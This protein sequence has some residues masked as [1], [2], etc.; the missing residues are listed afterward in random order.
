MRRCLA[1][2][3]PVALLGVALG[4]TVACSTQKPAPRKAPVP[5]PDWPRVATVGGAA[6]DRQDDE[7]EWVALLDRLVAQNVSVVEADSALSEYLNDD[8]FEAELT[9]VRRFSE[10][11]H[12][13]NLKVV[14]YYPSLEVITPNGETAEHSMFKDHPDWV[15][16]GL[17]EQDP[18]RFAPNVFYGSKVFWVAPGAESAWMCHLSP[19]REYLLGRIRKVAATGVDGIWLD[20][21]LFNDIVGKWACYHDL[22]R[23]KFHA[24]TGYEIPRLQAPGAELDSNDPAWRVWV[25]WRHREIDTFLRDVLAA[26]RSVRPDIAL[27]VET[28]TMDYNAA[29]LEGLDGSFAGP[30]ADYWHVWEVDVLSDS[31]AMT[32]ANEDDWASLA[33]MFKFGRGADR[34]R[35][36]WTFTY[37][38]EPDDAEAVLAEALAA[39]VCPYELKVPEMTTTVGADYRRRVFGWI[40]AHEDIL[41][42]S[43]SA[44]RV[45]VVHSSA[46][47]DYRDGACVLGQGPLPDEHCGVS[48][49]ATWQ[50]PDPDLA[51]WTSDLDDSL[52]QSIYLAEYRGFVKALMRLHVP[53]DV[54]PAARLPVEAL[55]AYDLLILPDPLALSDAEAAALRGFVE[56][57]GRLLVTGPSPGALDERGLVRGSPAL[58]GLIADA[59]EGGCADVTASSGVVRYCRA[60]PGRAVLRTTDAEALATIQQAVEALSTAVVQTDA[61]PRVHLELYRLGPK[62]ILH[63]VNATGVDGSFSVVPQTFHVGV[64]AGAA[65]ITRV[66]ATSARE[67]SDREVPFVRAGDFV[68]FDA[69]VAIH[70]VFVLE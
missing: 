4:W 67:D 58:S 56:A 60:S 23:A 3:R 69:T 13:R 11:A 30:D 28:V 6:L 48:L 43:E 50:R 21:P 39:Q 9:M 19:Y 25:H 55:S 61:G 35:A 18:S 62:T 40:R 12:E 2:L 54:I 57:G 1:R 27:V 26:A 29:L 42:R 34:G 15:Q 65:P 37:G 41:F 63:A 32:H 10:L 47:R 70:S 24:D 66:L 46:S 44:A 20:V 53:H 51:W 64:R 36:A 33:A 31:N 16:L 14:W 59:P 68:E 17:D 8:E 49:Y 22:D 7:T 45:A 5:P 52:Y 38:F